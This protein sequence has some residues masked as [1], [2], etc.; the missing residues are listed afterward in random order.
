MTFS[1]LFKPVETYLQPPSHYVSQINACMQGDSSK[2][3]T[4]QFFEKF[5]DETNVLVPNQGGHH[6]S[7]K[8]SVNTLPM[9]NDSWI[10]E[11]RK[12]GIESRKFHFFN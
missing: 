1:E 5:Q 2:I 4:T 12:T 6:N 11:Y 9:N 8:A 7:N 3:M 10:S